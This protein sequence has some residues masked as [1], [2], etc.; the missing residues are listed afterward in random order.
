V[1]VENPEGLAEFALKNEAGWDREAIQLAM[2]SSKTQRVTLKKPIP[3]LFFYTTSFFDQYDNLAFYP[4]IYGHDAVLLGVLGKS[5][6]LSDRS[7]FIHNTLSPD[8]V[9]K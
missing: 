9:I 4:D 6:D 2:Q 3:V 8:A 7:L 5:G 1:R